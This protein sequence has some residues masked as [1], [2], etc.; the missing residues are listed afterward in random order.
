[1]ISS[2]RQKPQSVFVYEAT[3]EMAYIE[4]N[5]NAAIEPAQ[6]ILKDIRTTHLSDR[7]ILRIN[8]LDGSYPFDCISARTAKTL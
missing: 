1:M 5:D 7:E 3:N 4:G 8:A 2:A 6:V